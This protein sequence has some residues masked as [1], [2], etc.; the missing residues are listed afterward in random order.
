MRDGGFAS[1]L[2][3]MTLLVT[4]A[5]LFLCCSWMHRSKGK[6]LRTG[7]AL[8]DRHVRG[9]RNDPASLRHAMSIPHDEV[10]QAHVAAKEKMIREA[11]GRSQITL[12]PDIMTIGFA[13]RATAYE[14]SDLIFA[15]L[16][17]LREMA[18]SVDPVQLVFAGKAHPQDQGGKDL[19]RHVFE[20]AKQLR[21]C[22]KVVYLVDR[23]L[24]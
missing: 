23:G 18:R 20:A 17:R 16:E 6:P 11:Y 19:I 3:N 1:A 13:R 9:W 10:C 21:D 4:V 22:V 2:G 8:F 24:E 14:R 7:Q 15:R 12:D 5:A